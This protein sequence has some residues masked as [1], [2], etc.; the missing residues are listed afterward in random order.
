MQK[1]LN[2]IDKIKGCPVGISLSATPEDHGL[3]ALN[4]LLLGLKAFDKANVDFIEIN[5]SCPNVVHDVEISESGLDKNLVNRIEFINQEFIKKQ[6]RKIPV[7]IKLSNDTAIEQVEPMIDLLLN[8][9]FSGI[10]FGNTSINYEVVNNYIHSDD[11]KLYKFFT[12]N[13]GG[14]ISG[15]PLKKSSLE[16]C[17]EVNRI[18]LSKT[19]NKEF[20]VIRTGGVFEK[21]DLDISKNRGIKLNQW[22]TGYFEAFSKYGHALYKEILSQ[23]A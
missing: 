9:N 17:T 15:F 12:S 23:N 3:K 14:G 16:L 4:G 8:N 7:I 18:L 20:N 6:N 2:E 5:E 11:W 19:L 10:N 13:F 21:R 22:Y 1:K